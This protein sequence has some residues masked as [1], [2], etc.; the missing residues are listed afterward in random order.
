MQP[1][2]HD[3]NSQGADPGNYQDILPLDIQD[4][5][6]RLLAQ[7]DARAAL[8]LA[9]TSS[10]QNV[11]L[12]S[13]ARDLH[14]IGGL[15]LQ[16]PTSSNNGAGDGEVAPT[17]GDHV[18]VL[19][20]LGAHS[21]RRR[22]AVIQARSLIQAYARIVFG[23]RRA[24]RLFGMT[25]D[26]GLIDDIDPCCIMPIDG[27]RDER[28]DVL[29]LMGTTSMGCFGTNDLEERDLLQDWYDWLTDARSPESPLARS[30]LH[31]PG[32]ATGRI[33]GHMR[34][35]ITAIIVYYGV[36]AGRGAGS[37]TIDDG[38]NNSPFYP[39]MSLSDD[40]LA[41][42]ITAR[43]QREVSPESLSSWRQDKFWGRDDAVRGM[44]GSRDVKRA[45]EHAL[46]E[47]VACQLRGPYRTIE[48]MTPLRLLP[49]SDIFDMRVV[50][51]PTHVDTLVFVALRS[52][53]IQA[54]LSQELC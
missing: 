8:S 32:A 30:W 2:N 22:A 38:D 31:G 24:R 29:Q 28:P 44:L 53:L 17:L 48:K 34:E 49:F 10:A 46:S 4:A 6:M 35:S 41:R 7:T 52:S 20:A 39:V 54:M 13:P 26:I 12:L 42:V 51:A 33:F 36:E 21:S 50:F 1:D 5:I 25:S 19:V 14:A 9:A 23:S 18:R 27:H 40:Q 16:S 15:L 47:A 37:V 43:T 11:L 45:V 3:A